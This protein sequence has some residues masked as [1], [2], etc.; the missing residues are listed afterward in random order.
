V[1]LTGKFLSAS[2]EIRI[3]TNLWVYCDEVFLSEE[4]GSPPGSDGFRPAHRYGRFRLWS[5]A[6]SDLTCSVLIRLP[7]Q[8]VPDGP[9][10]YAA[11][12]SSQGVPTNHSRYAG[13]RR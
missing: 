7:D 9:E 11:T 6:A 10:L 2:R 8:S 1:D 3:V 4:T 5:Q 13:P 12:V